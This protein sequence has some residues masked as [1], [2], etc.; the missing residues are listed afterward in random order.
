MKSSNT[1][2]EAF[3]TEIRGVVDKHTIK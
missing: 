2:Y 1:E 3:L